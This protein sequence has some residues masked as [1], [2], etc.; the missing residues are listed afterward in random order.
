MKTKHNQQI[1]F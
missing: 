1:S